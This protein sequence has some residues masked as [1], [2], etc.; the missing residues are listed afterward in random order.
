MLIAALI[1]NCLV[2]ALFIIAAVKYGRG[3]VPLTYHKLMLE[4]EATTLSPYLKLVLTAQYRAFGGAMLAIGVMIVALTLGPI[5]A[6]EF[7]AEVAVL[8]AG[9]AFVSGSSLTPHRV[10]QITGIQTPWRLALLMGGMLLAA[11]ILA[12]LA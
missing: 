8:L 12:Q 2:A 9:A 6:G 11:F 1:L 5:R 10:E 7:W 4:K 3:P